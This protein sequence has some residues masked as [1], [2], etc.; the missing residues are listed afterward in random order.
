[1]KCLFEHWANMKTHNK[2]YKIWNIRYCNITRVMRY[3]DKNYI[4][5]TQIS[6][7]VEK[8]S[9]FMWNILIITTKP[10]HGWYKSFR[11][12]NCCCVISWMKNVTLCS[13]NVVHKISFREVAKE[14]IFL[15]SGSSSNDDTGGR[16]GR[17]WS[18]FVWMLG[19]ISMYLHI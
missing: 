13:K 5:P 4:V 2:E 17:V 3:W 15:L 1:M 11:R 6:W 16:E 18:K 19:Y 14:L 8:T 12:R 10:L 7:F 9:I